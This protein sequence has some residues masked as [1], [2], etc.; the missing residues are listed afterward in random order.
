MDAAKLRNLIQRAVHIATPP[1]EART[2][3]LLAVRAIA[4]MGDLFSATGVEL[5]LER[6]AR[7]ALEEECARLRREVAQLKRRG[8]HQDD[9]E[10]KAKYDRDRPMDR[11]R[12]IAAKYQGFC[13]VC[14][15][16]YQAGDSIWWMKGEP[17]SHE[18]C[19]NAWGE[20]RSA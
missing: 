14:H 16:S 6:T 11:P 13:R 18:R 20:R 12:R 8:A 17:P 2:C 5:E 19:G 4:E 9:A 3:A 10:P 7:L 15:H 1:E